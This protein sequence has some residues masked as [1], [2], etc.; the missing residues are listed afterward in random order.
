MPNKLNE[1]MEQDIA[2]INACIAQERKQARIL[3]ISLAIAIACIIGGCLATVKIIQN[4][5]KTQLEAVQAYKARIADAA[6]AGA[7]AGVSII[8][9]GAQTLLILSCP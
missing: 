4:A 7:G 5:H 3:V 2:L 6:R 1:L 9:E 8:Q